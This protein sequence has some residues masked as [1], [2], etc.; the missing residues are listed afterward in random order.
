MQVAPAG[1]N[2]VLI[3]LGEVTAEELHA[4]ARAVGAVDGVAACVVGHSSLYVVFESSSPRVVERAIA[5]A[6]SSA[7]P[8]RLDDSRTRRLRVSFADAPD[9]A[10]FL[11]RTR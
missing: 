4:A 9:L 3:E 5:A 11:E 10:E 6:T 2:A 8:R 1:D 7:A